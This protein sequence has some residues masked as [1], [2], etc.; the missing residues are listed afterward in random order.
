MR[1]ADGPDGFREIY[2]VLERCDDFV[3]EVFAL[4]GEVACKIV[5][6]KMLPKALDRIEVGTVRRQIN[7]F[8]VMP[9]QALGFVP[10]GIVQHEQHAFAARQ[11]HLGSHRVEEH[12]KYLRVAM[13]NDETYQLAARRIDRSLRDWKA[14]AR[15][16]N[17]ADVLVLMK[18]PHE[19][20]V[21]EVDLLFLAQPAAKFDD[22][23]V[24]LV[25]KCRIIHQR[26]DV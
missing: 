22:R 16:G 25:R 15:A 6:F 26:K 8:D 5:S 7:R 17:L 10:A 12:L 4:F 3:A 24:G 13:E 14:R 9:T 11:W 2:Q 19:R 18:I 1:F 20:A 23:P 21:A